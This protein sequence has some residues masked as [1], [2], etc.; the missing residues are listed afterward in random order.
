MSY[1]NYEYPHTDP[2][3]TNADWLLKTMKELQEKIDGLQEEFLRITKEYVDEQIAI[4]A[5]QIDA[6]KQDF[7][8]FKIEVSQDQD[9]FQREISNQLVVFDQRINNLHTEILAAVV[10]VNARTDQAIAQNNDYILEEISKTI[11]NFLVVDYFTGNLVTVQEMFDKLA[12]FHVEDSIIYSVLAE[13]NN[14]YTDLADYHITYTNL[15]ISG[16]TIIIS[17]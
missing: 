12:K 2:D 9:T 15:V 3:R 7:E 5:A 16:N 10:S 1:Y 4:Y 17:K 6:L 8:T 13:R 11:A 14:T